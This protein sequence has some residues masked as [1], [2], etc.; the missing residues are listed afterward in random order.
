[1]GIEPILVPV[2]VV[3]GENSTTLV[4]VVIEV[5]GSVVLLNLNTKMRGEV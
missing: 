2:V 1:M 5:I 4:A 3:T